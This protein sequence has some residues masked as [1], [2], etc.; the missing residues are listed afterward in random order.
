MKSDGE[1]TTF[2]FRE[3]ATF[4]TASPTNVFG[5]KWKD[6]ETFKSQRINFLWVCRGTVA[7]LM[8][9]HQKYGNYLGRNGATCNRSGEK[10]VFRMSWGLYNVAVQ[11]SKMEML[12]MT[13]CKFLSRERMEK[14]S[15]QAILCGSSPHLP[16]LWKLFVDQGRDGFLQGSSSRWDRILTWKPM[17]SHYQEDLAKLWSSRT[18]SIEIPLFK[19]IEI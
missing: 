13:S 1:A 11:A 17:E 10:M 15:L 8:Q 16:K 9:A 14:W 4:R 18:S 5:W 3:K 12:P 6:Q 2:D 19:D 7:G